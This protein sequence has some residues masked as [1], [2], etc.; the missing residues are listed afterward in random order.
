MLDSLP[1]HR[2]SK[3]SLMMCPLIPHHGLTCQHEWEISKLLV[4]L[5]HSTLTLPLYP[6]KN[7]KALEIKVREREGIEGKEEKQQKINTTY[8]ATGKY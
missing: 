3:I 5:Y 8:Q 6:R 4:P 1:N 7:K 2:V